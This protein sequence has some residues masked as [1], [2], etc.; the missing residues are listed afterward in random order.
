M[1]FG[2]C[3]EAKNY[4]TLA[5]IGYDFIELSG[6]EIFSM[7]QKEWKELLEKIRAVGVPCI[8]FNDYC[9][10]TPAIVGDGFNPVAIRN[11]AQR[12]LDR[13]A[14]LQI[15]N[16]GIGAPTARKLPSEYSR[17]LAEEQCIRFLEITAEEA[18]KRG[19]QVLFEAVHS[20]LCDFANHTEDAV[21]LIQEVAAPNL[22]MVLDFYHME[23]MGENQLS[24]ASYIPYIRH[25]HFSHCAAGYARRYL[26]VQDAKHIAE[27]LSMLK[28]AGYDKTASVE[29][30][31][32]NFP[33]DAAQTMEVFR[34]A[35]GQ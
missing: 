28:S 34:K 9:R 33:A 1:K 27:I 23:V 4:E 11:Y 25:V 20:H 17:K 21:R 3:T 16:V 29:A 32:E 24:I 30:D 7:E 26:N 6:H 14:Q 22:F 8:G 13:G 18:A 15:Q 5:S 10:Y 19:I 31:T 35:D 2:C 12:L